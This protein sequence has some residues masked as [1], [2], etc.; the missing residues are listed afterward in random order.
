MIQRMTKIKAYGNGTWPKKKNSA[1]GGRGQGE[2]EGLMGTGAPKNNGAVVSRTERVN[3]INK[4]FFLSLKSS[5]FC[6]RDVSPSPTVE[7][8]LQE[9]SDLVR[10][11][12]VFFSMTAAPR[13]AQTFI[14]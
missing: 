8:C 7:M 4:I 13:V 6:Q 9:R 14:Y 5:L 1:A 2:K 3:K 10:F 12:P 11:T